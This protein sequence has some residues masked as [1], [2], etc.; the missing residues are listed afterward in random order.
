MKE[1]VIVE[2]C[3]GSVADCI[4]ADAAGA[5][6]IEL[7][8]ALFLGGLTPSLGTFTQARKVTKI[9][10]IIMVRPRGGGFYYN[11]IEKNTMIQ[12]AK[13][14][15]EHGAEGLAFGFLNEDCSIDI[16]T[17]KEFVD[18]CHSSNREAV[19]H[20]AFDRCNDP[21]K[22]IEDLID[23]GVDRILTSGLQASAG[24][25]IELLKSLQETYGDKIELLVGSGVNSFNVEKIVSETKINQVHSSFKGWFNDAT[26]SGKDVS[27]AYSDDG[28]YDGTSLEKLNEFI[29]LLKS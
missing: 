5:D 2:V 16:E 25:G 29:N 21:I 13:T 20:R 23:L 28:D 26:T 27:Y 14:F 22:G 18:L 4:V 19:F 7:N 3:A 12:D 15:I 9:P 8:N 10:M 1:K 17:T 11:D 24:D 6:R